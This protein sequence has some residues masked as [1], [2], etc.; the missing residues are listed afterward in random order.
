MNHANN[1]RVCELYLQFDDTNVEHAKA[2]LEIK[3]LLKK[4][5]YQDTLEIFLKLA[6]QGDRIFQHNAGVLFQCIE[7]VRN[8]DLAFD[9]YQAAVAQD[10]APAKERLGSMYE[11]GDG[12]L[13]IDLSAAVRLYRE[14]SDQGNL[15]SIY[16]LGMI[17]ARGSSC[18]AQNLP[19]AERLLI[20]AARQG[21]ALMKLNLGI[22]YLEVLGNETRANAWFKKAYEQDSYVSIDLGDYYLDRYE[23][24][25]SGN[26]SA[27]SHYWFAIAIAC[28]YEK[29]V[30]TFFQNDTAVMSAFKSQSRL[31]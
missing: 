13:P 28:G 26:S 29:D 22:I 23:R 5:C 2:Q 31:H 20:R 27:L 24:H 11:F 16:N 6:T 9:W 12:G 15:H 1:A 14:S 30:L 3:Q 21:H 17:L 19:V 18:T 25:V 8:Y 7:Q 4:H 10:Y